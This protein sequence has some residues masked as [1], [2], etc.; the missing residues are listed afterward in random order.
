MGHLARYSMRYTLKEIPTESVLLLNT[1]EYELIPAPG[2]MWINSVYSILGCL[3]WNGVAYTGANDFEI[4]W[5]D[6]NGDKMGNLNST[7]L[8]STSHNQ[9]QYICNGEVSPQENA[10]VIAHVPIANPG[11]GDSS[12]WIW[13]AYRRLP[14]HFYMLLE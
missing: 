3:Q 4:R 10:P 6:R 7:W 2:M 11:A 1:T 12:L 8:N 14:A 13:T 5:G 9:R